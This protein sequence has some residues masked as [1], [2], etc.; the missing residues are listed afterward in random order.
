MEV[1]TTGETKKRRY[2]RVWGELQTER[3]SYDADYKDLAAHI[4]PRRTRYST[5]EAGQGQRKN[6]KIINNTATI[7]ARVLASGMMAGLSS[8]A[9]P[10]VRFTTPDPQIAEMG[11]A[12]WW[13]YQADRAV[14]E[15]FAK[16]NVYLSLF[17]AYYDL[18]TFAVSAFHIDEDPR[19]II[20]TRV[21][22]VGSYAIANNA[23]LQVDTIYR[24]DTFT[25]SQL[26]EEYCTDASGE[27][28][29]SNLSVLSRDKWNRKQ[30]SH[31]VDVLHI[32]EPNRD[33]R[34][35]KMESKYKR[36]SSCHFELNA[37]ETDE[38]YLRESGYDDFPTPCPRWDITGEDAYGNSCPG[39]DAIG[40]VRALQKLEERSAD[41]AS[42]LSKPPMKGPASLMNKRVSIVPGD[43]TL[44]DGDADKFQ[45]SI[46][47]HPQAVEVVEAK[48]REHERRINET[49]YANFWIG[50]TLTQ[51]NTRTATE[52]EELRDEKLIQLGP[53]VER[54]RNELL[55]PLVKRTLQTLMKLG[56]LPPPPQE[57]MMQGGGVKVEYISI[58]SQ[59]QKLLGIAGVERLL[60]KASELAATRPDVWDVVD[61]DQGMQELG[62]MLSVPS[63][64][65]RTDDQVAAIR[66][67]RA[68]Q[69]AQQA[70]A[71]QIQQGSEVAKNLGQ[72]KTDGGTALSDM[73]NQLGAPTH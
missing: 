47:I 65:I 2:R 19:T 22:P 57:M 20:R 15:V 64:M 55:D 68:Q 35:G 70:K 6:S 69:M 63:K 17:S 44:V 12:K 50:L 38:L 37:P 56:Y 10:W 8:P 3:S 36:Y 11:A 26:V 33:Y 27:V 24:V 45:P 51:G 39:M 42:K 43:I 40:D 62:D 28:D 7:A 31:K 4:L 72:A 25:V 52:V 48:L 32:V 21:F 5:S 60:L 61:L 49:Y 59:A 30:L 16:S 41:L 71:Q 58:L 66:G 67:A 23:R 73:L 1:S 46:V 13:L 18:G 54:I 53:V 34:P 29:V 9:R 14:L